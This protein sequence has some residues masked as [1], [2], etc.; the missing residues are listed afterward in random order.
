VDLKDWLKEEIQHSLTWSD[1][2]LN[3][4]RSDIKCDAQRNVQQ[5]VDKRMAFWYDGRAKAYENILK[6]IEEKL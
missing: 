3:M 2:W 6:R 4:D 5:E 1:A